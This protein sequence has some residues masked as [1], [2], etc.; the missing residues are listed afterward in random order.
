MSDVHA[1]PVALET[2]LADARAAGCGRFILLGDITGYGY[3]PKRALDISRES[4]DVVLL[5]N[6]DSA[7][8]GLDPEWIV[9][10]NGNYDLDRKARGELSAEDIEWL[11]GRG[12]LHEE[13][14]FAG[15]HGDF[16]RPRAWN[17]VSSCRD[18]AQSFL[19]RREAL[20]FCGHTH[21]AAVWERLAKGDIRSRLAARLGRPA[22]K[23]ES[24]SFVMNP[25]RRYIV[26]V[27]SVGYPR[28]DLCATYVIFDPE[29]R[30]VTLRR[31]PFDFRSYISEMIARG[32]DLP[33]WLCAILLAAQGEDRAR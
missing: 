3:D 21:E 22:A 19:A 13:A 17:Y 11:R 29:E 28:H 32:I 9:A 5:G 15:V 25:A 24:I 27:G 14:G 20:M 31:L 33:R 10:S 30:R 4:F 8:V 26:N 23:A 12:L 18:A 2:A 1:N 6:H 16:V 7:C